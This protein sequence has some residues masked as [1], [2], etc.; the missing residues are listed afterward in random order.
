LSWLWFIKGL[1][2]ASTT[3]LRVAII[4]FGPRALG[5]LESLTA[6]AIKTRLSAKIDIFD[7]FPYPGAGPN[8][9]PDQS[10]LCILNIPVR[11]LTY[12]PPKFMSDHIPPFT[13]WV[14]DRFEQ[15]EFPPRS[16]V[17]SYLT[18]RFQAL[19]DA[20]PDTLDIS[21]SNQKIIGLKRAGEGWQIK[22]GDGQMKTYNE[23]LLT[24][25]QPETA[26]DP[27]LQRWINHAR[28]HS[29][30]LT[31]AYPAN[32]LIDFAQ[33]WSNDT[34]AVRGMGLSTLDVLR[35][36]TKGLG[37]RFVNGRYIASGREPRKILPF[38]LNG[39]A[40]SA[41]PATK[42]LDDRFNPTDAEI[43]LFETAL[44]KTT[45]SN[46]DDALVEI[47]RALSVPATRILSDVKSSDTAADVDLWLEIERRDPGAQ[48][49]LC[50][51]D[52]LKLDIE[53]AHGRVLPSAG[54]TIGQVWRKLQGELRSFFNTAEYPVETASALIGFDEAMKRYSYG[55]PVFAA[56][57]LL[58]LIDH[59][60]VSMCIVDDP[61]ILLS[62]QGWQL[63]E[64]DEAMSAQVMVDAVIPSPALEKVRDTLMVECVK[65][66]LAQQVEEGLGAKTDASAQLLD[67]ANL[68]VKG[69]CMLGR[70]TIGSVIAVDGLNDCFGPSTVRWAEG[71]VDRIDK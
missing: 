26:P 14:S 18:K 55:P 5:A 19:C 17:G 20:A 30:D 63:I 58:A 3:D 11:I 22:S 25:G 67:D 71:V 57:E 60:I 8:F 27:Q 65:S 61:A 33:G 35:M 66:G 42:L 40:P 41:K 50:A 39:K 21:H 70:L 49:V 9:D 47:C 4:G 6:I 7:P 53:V 62:A 23:V 2:M 1:K 37:G 68:P 15:D 32:A 52:A 46:P 12:V 28:E 64:D 44:G 48:D 69:L 34:V 59:G 38:S 16:I 43:Q 56:E 10:D 51:V 29:L 31:H 36:L 54:Y 24:Q 13:E 45:S